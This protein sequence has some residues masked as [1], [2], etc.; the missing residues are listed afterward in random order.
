MVPLTF[1]AGSAI[2]FAGLKLFIG[3]KIFHHVKAK[4][5]ILLKQNSKEKQAGNN[6]LEKKKVAHRAFIIS[7]SSLIF[8]ILGTLFYP[9][10]LFISV[11]GI[12]YNLVSLWY[13][14][15][16]LI[17]QENRA[18]IAIID[19]ATVTGLLVTKYYV[20]AALIDWIFYSLQWLAF[21]VETDFREGLL[22]L[23]GVIPSSV[24]LWQDEV[25]IEVPIEE[26]KVGDI[27]VMH[28]G[29]IIPI[30]GTLVEGSVLVN[31]AIF[32]QDPQPV[33]KGIGDQLIAFTEIVSGKA[34]VKLNKSGRETMT[35]KINKIVAHMTEFNATT[36]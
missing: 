21:K 32:T 25:E 30:D 20:T 3:L 16:K 2:A 36:A 28:A 5:T 27:V 11:F 10:L 14:L 31:Q 8:A 7:S 35:A 9:P 24:W 22:N 15:L 23:L 17:F 6:Y 18:N 4:P 33:M 26:A 1:I 34:L 12:V 13:D 29:D 19:A